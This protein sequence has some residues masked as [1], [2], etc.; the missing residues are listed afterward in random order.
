[1]KN[2]DDPMSHEDLIDASIAAERMLISAADAYVHAH[3]EELE[4]HAEECGWADWP[5][6][7]FEAY[8][9]ACDARHQHHIE[10]D[11]EADVAAF[12]EELEEEDHG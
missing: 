4:E 8:E 6:K 9:D 5:L 1:M 11:I 7:N 10:Q 2:F 3:L 12:R